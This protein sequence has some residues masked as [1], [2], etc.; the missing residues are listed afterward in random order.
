MIAG[1]REKISSKL[2]NN[3]NNNKNEER[4]KGKETRGEKKKL[5]P[6]IKREREKKK[7]CNQLASIINFLTIFEEVKKEIKKANSSM[8]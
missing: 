1:K 5:L 6:S 2:G 3:N 4:K 7:Q 8:M